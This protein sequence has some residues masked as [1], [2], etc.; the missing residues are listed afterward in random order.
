L[1]VRSIALFIVAGLLEI[2]GG[3]LI[4]QP[5][6][7]HR[8]PWHHWAWCLLG[9]QPDFHDVSQFQCYKSHISFQSRPHIRFK[10]HDMFK[11]RPRTDTKFDISVE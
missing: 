2:A 3:W 1:V 4:W 7:E 8:P 6:R 5:L 11:S 10:V 9:V